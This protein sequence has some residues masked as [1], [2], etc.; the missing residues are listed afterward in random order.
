MVVLPPPPAQQPVFSMVTQI[1][2]FFLFAFGVC[3]LS[4]FE[5]PRPHLETPSSS[6][7]DFEKSR[8]IQKGKNPRFCP[9]VARRKGESFVPIRLVNSGVA[10]RGGAFLHAKPPPLPKEGTTVSPPLPLR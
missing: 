6:N 1:P 9:E 7:G 8:T 4:L 2:P 5:E 3:L 10:R